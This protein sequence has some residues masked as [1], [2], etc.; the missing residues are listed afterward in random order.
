MG[1]RVSRHAR[2]VLILAGQPD[3]RIRTFH[4]PDGV[5][6]IVAILAPVQYAVPHCAEICIVI[7]KHDEI[8][9]VSMPLI[10]PPQHRLLRTRQAAEYLCMSEWKLRRLIQ[11][12]F[13]PYLHGGE[14]APFLL[15]IRDLDEYIERNK[16]HDT[17]DD[18]VLPPMKFPA[19]TSPAG[20]KG[21]ISYAPSTRNRKPV[22]AERQR[23][24]VN[25][26]SPQ[27]KAVS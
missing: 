17:P 27:R 22:S 12:G 16:H 6:V 10:P 14:G 9:E 1:A 11:D 24:L 13:L 25:Q 3:F 7:L 8:D 23:G 5:F 2:H 20:K 19:F 18:L 4:V 15:D 26:V 21:G